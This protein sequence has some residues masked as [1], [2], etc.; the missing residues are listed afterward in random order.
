MFKN[1]SLLMILL[2]LGTFGQSNWLNP[3]SSALKRPQNEWLQV[4]V[5]PSVETA[6]IRTAE[7]YLPFA[8]STCNLQKTQEER[9]PFEYN[10]ESRQRKCCAL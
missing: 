3:D 9:N 4:D 6:E 7:C 2:L 10:I 8:G 1:V 5:E